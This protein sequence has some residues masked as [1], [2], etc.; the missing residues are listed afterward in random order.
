MLLPILRL[1]E[2]IGAQSNEPP[3]LKIA[4]TFA[5]VP[6]RNQF[7]ES[8]RF[9]DRFVSDG[10]AL[11]I[12]TMFTTC[13]GTCPGTSA[14]LETLRK[15]MSL[16][17]GRRLSIVSISIDP[18]VDDPKRLLEYSGMFGAERPRAD[19]CEWQFVTGAPRD[20]DRLRWSL[21][22]F[23]LDPRRD[24]DIT[25]H[26]ATLLFGN[27]TSDRWSTI[28]AEMKSSLIVSTIRRVAGFTFEQKY[29]LP[30]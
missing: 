26:A 10:R 16:V 4:D 13:R 12:N 8:I 20:I 11:I 7:G 18:E 24:Q 27:S 5:N 30:S 28:P 2:A 9:H 6:L 21:G 23:D 19:L 29:G 1:L 15:T 14:T 17:F 22:F 3:R 25:Q